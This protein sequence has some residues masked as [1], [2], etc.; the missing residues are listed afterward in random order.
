MNFDEQQEENAVYEM[1]EL[2]LNDMRRAGRKM[3]F[4]EVSEGPPIKRVKEEFDPYMGDGG[5]ARIP[6]YEDY[7]M[8]LKEAE[9]FHNDTKVYLTR[10][11][12][13]GGGRRNSVKVEEL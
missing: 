10:A 6:V 4:V 13:E 9:K 7:G 2:S 3:R 12:T 8:D 1:T 5:Y 11:R